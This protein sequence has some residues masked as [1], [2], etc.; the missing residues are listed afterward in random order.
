MIKYNVKYTPELNFNDL[1][2]ISWET[3]KMSNIV[4]ELN[5]D[6]LQVLNEIYFRQEVYATQQQKTLEYF[7]N[8]DFKKLLKALHIIEQLKSQLIEQISDGQ[9][10]IDECI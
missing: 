3:S 8:G 1:Q 4:N 7:V 6:C 10:K 5:Y 2:K 9:F